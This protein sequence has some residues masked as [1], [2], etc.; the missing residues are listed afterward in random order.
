MR[1]FTDTRRVGRRLAALSTG[2]VL[3]WSAIAGPAAAAP[4]IR[5]SPSPAAAPPKLDLSRLASPYDAGQAM[6]AAGVART[7]I[8]HSLPSQGATAS[9]GFLCG[10]P[11]NTGTSGASGAL[12]TDRDGRFVGA[13]LRLGFR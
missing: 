10:G 5:L 1:I 12:G 9:L 6:R 3:T 7:A 4:Q 8:D 13:Q 2:L 11:P